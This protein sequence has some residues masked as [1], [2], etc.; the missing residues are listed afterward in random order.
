[1]E[2]RNGTIIGWICADGRKQQEELGKDEAAS[3]TVM[4][5]SVL[6]TVAI[7]ASE[8]WD[9]AVID[10]PGACLPACRYG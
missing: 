6:I 2:K 7:E 1:M 9:V 8:N 4:V 5:D 10:L 3:P